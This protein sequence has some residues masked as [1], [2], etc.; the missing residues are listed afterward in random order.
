MNFGCTLPTRGQ[1][2]TPDTLRTLA[3]HAEELGYDSVWVSDHI[4]IPVEVVTPYP[5]TEGGKS[6]F[7]PGET[8][9]EALATLNYLAGLTKKIKLGT[10]VII[11][12]YRNPLVTAKQVASLDFLSQ[13]RVIF[14]VGAGWMEEEFK[15]LGYDYYKRRGAVTDEQIKIIRKVWTEETTSFEGE[16]YKFQPL[17]IRPVPV[18]RPHPPIWIGGHSL[19]AI[20]R[21]ARLGDGWMPVGLQ[22]SAGL[23]PAEMSEKIGQ[24]RELAE[25]AGRDPDSIDVCLSAALQLG[26]E[27]VGDSRDLFAGSAEQVAEDID[28]YRQTGVKYFL[29]S[30][31]GGRLL[32]MSRE[33]AYAGQRAME[34]FASRVMPLV[35]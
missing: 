24:L 10:H 11:L 31:P 1:M 20:R 34:E 35:R 13:G 15:A 32:G 22:G 8:Y 3:Q 18:Q 16:F 19:A 27:S 2:V 33:D 7:D 25:G 28:K 5:Y 9:V 30:F 12:P 17:S 29:F 4:A 6:P 23:A 14:G 26:K 21:A